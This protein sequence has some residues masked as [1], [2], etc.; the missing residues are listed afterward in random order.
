MPF[1]RQGSPSIASLPWPMPDSFE[2]ICIFRNPLLKETLWDI[3][4]IFFSTIIAHFLIGMQMAAVG[5]D[6]FKI[7]I[8]TLFRVWML[9]FITFAITKSMEGDGFILS[10]TFIFGYFEGLTDIDIWPQHS[11]LPR[12]M[13]HNNKRSLALASI[14][15]MSIIS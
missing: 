9:I 7:F 1:H 10:I 12:L 15:V 3:N 14:L 13:Q 4:I 8:H 2:R 11:L 6:A 5:I